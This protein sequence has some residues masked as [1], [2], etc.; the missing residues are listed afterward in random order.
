MHSIISGSL[1]PEQKSNGMI[2][3]HLWFIE[4]S[5]KTANVKYGE[6]ELWSLKVYQWS[7]IAWVENTF[8]IVGSVYECIKSN[9]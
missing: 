4:I 3:I 6:F 5:N 7:L 9:C 1:K 8:E 2:L